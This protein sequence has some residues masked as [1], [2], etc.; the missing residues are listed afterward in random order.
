[1]S[2]NVIRVG[3]TILVTAPSRISPTKLAED[4]RKQYPGV[5]VSVISVDQEEIRV[6]AHY[7]PGRP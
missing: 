6:V 3:D 1:M 4:L 7:R 5:A 2:N